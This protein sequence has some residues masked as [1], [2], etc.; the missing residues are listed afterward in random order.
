VR[1][2]GLSVIANPYCPFRRLAATPPARAWGRWPLDGRIGALSVALD[3]RSFVTEQAANLAYPPK[4]P[5]FA[6][7]VVAEATYLYSDLE[8]ED[9]LRPLF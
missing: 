1:V 6:V 9:A 3:R 2:G 4:R 8:G 7:G 5:G